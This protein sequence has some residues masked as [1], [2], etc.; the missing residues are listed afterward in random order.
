MEIVV[1]AWQMMTKESVNAIMIY[2][3][4]CCC[5]NII[6]FA[7]LPLSVRSILITT[8]AI[9]YR[10]STLTRKMKVSEFNLY[11]IDGF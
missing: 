9:V 2:S 11:Q 1:P 8:K 7:Q 6:R 3:Q 5:F 10:A 4:S